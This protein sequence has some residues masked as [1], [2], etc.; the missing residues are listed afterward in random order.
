MP[1]VTCPSELKVKWR[2][3]ATEDEDRL[4]AHAEEPEASQAEALDELLAHLFVSVEHKGHY[5]FEQF[6]VNDCLS[7]DRTKY[8]IDVRNEVL[9]PEMEVREECPVG[10]EIRQVLDLRE[11][12]IEPLPEASARA[13]R[14][15]TPL[16]FT[17]PK[18]GR[19]V[20]WQ[21]LNGHLETAMLQVIRESPKQAVSEGLAVRVVAVDGFDGDGLDKET[22]EDL[23][24]WLRK[25]NSKDSRALRQHI[26]NN[27][28]GVKVMVTIPCKATGC[29]R[30]VRI[31]VMEAPDF[32][33]LTVEREESTASSD[34]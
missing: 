16:S 21:M 8:L 28:C 11:L 12:P 14:E 7:G 29:R 20:Q 24:G 32:F 25:L 2:E 5:R 6:D 9:E 13:L 1:I 33:P 22:S 4:A 30:K 31:N 3:M 27:E 17:L 26:A 23:R 10:H 19:V 34:S 15:G 18:T